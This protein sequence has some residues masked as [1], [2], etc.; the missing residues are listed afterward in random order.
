MVGTG[1]G[2]LYEGRALGAGPLDRADV[3]VWSAWDILCGDLSSKGLM[4]LSMV[5]SRKDGSWPH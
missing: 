1:S 4:N 3:L 2:D 5:G